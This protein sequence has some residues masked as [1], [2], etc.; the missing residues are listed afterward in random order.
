MVP[1]SVHY[2]NVNLVDPTTGQPTRVGTGFL[3]DGTKVR[4]SKRS[5]AIIPKPTWER[6]RPK[7]LV[8][9][10]LDTP[11]DDVMEVTYKPELDFAAFQK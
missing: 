2:S 3:D 8:I 7:N 10:P 11:T 5:G 9:G 4:I 6:T 1:A